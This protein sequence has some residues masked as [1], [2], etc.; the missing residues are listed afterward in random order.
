MKVKLEFT[1]GTGVEPVLDAD[2]KLIGVILSPFFT[3]ARAA[4]MVAKGSS[5]NSADEVVDECALI[6]S[7]S[8]GQLMRRVAPEA[9]I[10]MI[11][12]P[13]DEEESEEGEDEQ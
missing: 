4:A 8:T 9:V 3:S 11:D 13:K 6:V 10:P 1:P 2:D 5:L 12:K 7:G